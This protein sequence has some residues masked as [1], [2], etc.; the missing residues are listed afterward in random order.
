M[1]SRKVRYELT[2]PYFYLTRGAAPSSTPAALN[3]FRICLLRRQIPGPAVH[4][5]A[6]SLRSKG[7][8]IQ[9]WCRAEAVCFCLSLGPA[10]NSFVIRWLIANCRFKICRPH[11]F[12]AGLWTQVFKSYGYQPVTI[13]LSADPGKPISGRYRRLGARPFANICQS[14]YY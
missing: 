1:F 5:Q 9:G 6:K 10:G 14:I 3:P 13:L 11:L 2:T 7:A 4:L 12:S 8:S